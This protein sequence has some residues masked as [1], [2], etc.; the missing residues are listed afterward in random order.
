MANCKFRFELWSLT[1]EVMTINFCPK[2]G[3]LAF[4]AL[5]CSLAPDGTFSN[6]QGSPMYSKRK[7]YERRKQGG[8]TRVIRKMLH[9]P[10]EN[11]GIIL[12]HSRLVN[13]V[14]K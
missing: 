9:I 7:R 8:L 4:N 3:I 1:L 13:I 12:E 10:G 5:Y 6:Y 11:S 2:A 14:K